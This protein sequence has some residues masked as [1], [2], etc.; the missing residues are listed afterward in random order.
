MRLS[1]ISINN[2]RRRKGKM[3]FV[4][5]GL[6]IGVATMVTMFSITSAMK[7]D[8][9][10]KLDEYGANIVIT[11]KAND[12]ALTYGGIAV[13]GV[14]YDVKELSQEDVAT[15]RTIKNSENLSAVAPKLFGAALVEGNQVLVV[16]VDFRQEMRLKKWWEV[17]GQ[18][19]GHPSEVLLGHLAAQKLQKSPGDPLRIGDAD[20]SVAGVLDETGSQEDSLVYVDLGAA[21]RLLGKPGKVSM[22]EV[23]AL[24]TSCPIEEIVAQISEVLPDA[25]VSALQQAVKARE[26]T[27]EQL[28]NFSLAVSVVV[29]FVGALVVLNTMMS[30]INE[31]TREIGIFRAI[32]FRKVHV[33]SIILLEA[34]VVSA[35]AGV[36]GWIGGTL[37]SAFVAPRLAQLSVGLSWDPGLGMAAI[38][39]AI[40]VGM[41]SS[42]YPA[43]RASNLD[44]AEAL[45]FI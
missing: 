23:A 20:F 30:S 10:R 14:A 2:L 38:A 8:T 13:A 5:L 18:V 41:V 25:R 15:I 7:A 21:Q 36:L 24:C 12:L 3:A 4:T 27:V 32:G 39:L 35:L 26:Q 33:M 37:I 29:L 44:P 1:T 22:V 34:L 11:P 31:R 9:E 40:V 16:G 6:L 45:R 28:S 19:P 17:Q 42:V 43:V